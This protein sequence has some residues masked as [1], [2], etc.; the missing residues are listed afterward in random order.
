MSIIE[1]C[2]VLAAHPEIGRPRQFSRKE[3]EGIRSFVI[4]DYPNY[5][6]FYRA[7]AEGV[8]IIR[9]LHGARNLDEL[10]E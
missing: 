3:L 2:K 9:V 5:I 4:A 6:I 7:H 8:Q 1:I 10:F